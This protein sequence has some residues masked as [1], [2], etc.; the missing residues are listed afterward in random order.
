MITNNKKIVEQTSIDPAYIGTKTGKCDICRATKK[1]L[2]LRYGFS[3]CEDCLYICTLIL[4]H[5]QLQ[6][7]QINSSEIPQ[8]PKGRTES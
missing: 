2:L 3:L 6:E 1:I 4:E 7:D 8:K 5:L